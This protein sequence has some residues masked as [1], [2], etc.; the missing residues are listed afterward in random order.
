MKDPATRKHGVEKVDAKAVLGIFVE[1]DAT[2]FSDLAKPPAE[3]LDH[4]QII[5]ILGTQTVIG[6]R[7]EDFLPRRVIFVEIVNIGMRRE[8]FTENGSPGTR[9]TRQENEMGK[10]RR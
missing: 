6:P 4:G 2:R 7:L 10:L 9:A 1:N 5:G 3:R 8:H